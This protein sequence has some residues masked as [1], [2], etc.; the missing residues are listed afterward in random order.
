M[1]IQISLSTEAPEVDGSRSAHTILVSSLLHYREGI[2]RDLDTARFFEHVGT[3]AQHE[4]DIQ[5]ID[6]IIKS[7]GVAGVQTVYPQDQP[8]SD[9]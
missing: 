1:I 3:I 9:N 6:E 5:T 8:R 7:L 4:R 2:Q